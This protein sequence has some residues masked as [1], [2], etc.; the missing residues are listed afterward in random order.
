MHRYNHINLTFKAQKLEVLNLIWLSLLYV[1]RDSSFISTQFFVLNLDGWFGLLSNKFTLFFLYI[2]LLYY[3]V[4][5]RSSITFC[6]SS[7]YIYLSFFILQWTSWDICNSIRNIFT[8]QIT[9]F[10][11]CFSNYFF[12]SSF[13]CICSRLFSMINKSL[14]IFI[15]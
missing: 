1:P 7:G 15:I 10:F 2:L 5:L 14:T 4:N 6:L 12:W 13:K 3:D 9:S 8:N 11:C